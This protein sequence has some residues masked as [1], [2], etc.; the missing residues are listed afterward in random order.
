MYEFDQ[1][2]SGMSTMI[3]R[4]TEKYHITFSLQFGIPSTYF[5]ASITRKF[6]QLDEEEEENQSKRLKSFCWYNLENALEKLH[7]KVQL[8]MEVTLKMVIPQGYT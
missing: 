3:V 1:E 4:S 8:C 5:M 6:H 7:V 2:Q